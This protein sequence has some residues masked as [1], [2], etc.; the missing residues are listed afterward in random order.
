MSNSNNPSDRM[1]ERTPQNADTGKRSPGL[2]ITG[3]G[4]VPS[5]PL[6]NIAPS[7]YSDT[8]TVDSQ[9]QR[10]KKRGGRK[11]KEKSER[12]QSVSE[13]DLPKGETSEHDGSS[14]LEGRHEDPNREDYDAENLREARSSRASGSKQR[15]PN[16]AREADTGIRAFNLKR[17]ESSRSRRPFGIRVE[18]PKSK[19]RAHKQSKKEVG[20]DC[21][22]EDEEDEETEKKTCL[23]IRFDINLE[24]EVFLK[25]KIKGDITMT[26]L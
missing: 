26:F 1:E 23:S 2:K 21:S 6:S 9:Q 5:P 17:V 25:A 18:R 13:F 11:K 14:G 4:R 15:P 24:V 20:E 22:Q 16:K 7:D 19:G 8:P 10:R 3:N 12:L